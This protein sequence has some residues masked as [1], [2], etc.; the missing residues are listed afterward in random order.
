MAEFAG[1]QRTLEERERNFEERKEDL[2]AARDELSNAFKALSGDVLKTSTAQFL[3]QADEVLKRYKENAEGDLKTRQ[4]AIDGLL[5]PMKDTLNKLEEGN[6]AMERRRSHAYGELMEQVKAL[7][8]QQA[9]LH[10][11]TGRLVKALQDPGSAGSWGEMVLERV[12]EM[13]GLEEGV[14]FTTQQTTDDDD[15]RQRPDV[16]VHLPGARLIVIDSKAPMRNYLDA[17][18]ATDSEKEA[19]L[20]AHGTKLFEHSKELRRRD[21]SKHA[22]APDFTVMF[23]GS[24]AAFRAAMEA[25][26]NLTEDVL[27]N[28]VVIATPSTLL[29]LLRA[30]AY[31]W[32]QEKLAETAREVQEDGR[33]LY[34]TVCKLM[35]HYGRLGKALGQAGKAYNEF[36]GSLELRVLPAARRFKDAGV[37]SSADLE[38][39]EPTELSPRALSAAEFSSEDL[40]PLPGRA[41]V[42]QGG[43]QKSLLD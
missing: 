35:E 25:R 13:S 38:S 9:K 27:A 3:Q 24:E 42:I 7:N 39:F 15:Q 30:V 31:G 43:E 41:A 23:I 34:E 16:F 10:T 18:S 12:L 40:E 6:Q 8:D 19:L 33:R 20:R 21:Y 4:E 37:H 11:E 36:G 26:P 5:K 17:L 28:N 2:L 22:S 29:A 1:L 32:R 14:N